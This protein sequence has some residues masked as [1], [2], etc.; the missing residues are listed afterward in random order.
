[1]SPS[2]RSPVDGAAESGFVSVRPVRSYQDI[3]HQIRDAL[4]SGRIQPG[5]RLPSE[6]ALCERF[7]VSRSTLREALRSLEALGM[8]EVRLG[9]SGGVFACEPS[10]DRASEAIEALF[11]FANADP[12][13]LYEFRE[14][15]EAD[16]AANAARRATES[17]VVLLDEALRAFATKANDLS[18]PWSEVAAADV[19]FHEVVADATHNRVRMAVMQAI[20]SAFS[21]TAQQSLEG[22]D[23]A[24]LRDEHVRQLTQ[25]C[26]A[27]STRDTEAA[28][29]AM[30]RHI[31]FFTEL[32]PGP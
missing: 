20:H 30:R 9:S 7:A 16:T 6:R 5:D 24:E 23:T 15:F 2:N 13:E 10:V 1:M 14:S 26:E 11:W 27:I 28:R 18:A 31:S 29:A 3:V 19:A 21:R 17:D 4:F 25:V 8:I 12:A 32:A 22:R